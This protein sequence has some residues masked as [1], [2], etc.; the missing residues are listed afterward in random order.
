MTKRGVVLIGPMGSGKSAVGR[1]LAT[2]LGMAHVD[3]DSLV[4][5]RTGT[6]IP[7]I[8]DRDGERGFRAAEAAALETALED[9]P[10]VISTGGGIVEREPNRVRLADSGALIVWLDADIDTLAG[11]VGDGRGRPLLAG[12]PKAALARTVEARAPYYE[13]TAA[14]R[15]DTGDLTTGHCVDA[16]L[17]LLDHGVPA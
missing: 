13:E 7:E 8:F 3:T 10:C 15:L 6:T 12:D 4:V 11:R 1:A 14:V 2:R 9:M 17:A 16:I 5:E